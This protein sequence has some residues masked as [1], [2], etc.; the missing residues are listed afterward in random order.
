LKPWPVDDIDPIEELARIINEAQAQDAHDEG[1]FGDLA[2]LDPPKPIR[3]AT[4][5]RRRVWRS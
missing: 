5:P 3:A 1:R 4:Q 2:R